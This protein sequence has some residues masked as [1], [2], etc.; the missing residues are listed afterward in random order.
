MLEPVRRNNRKEI[1]NQ[2]IIERYESILKRMGKV[3]LLTY[4]Y[5]IMD[6]IASE[7]G[8]EPTT[9]ARIISG[10]VHEKRRERRA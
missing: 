1:R 7:F 9:V 8:I 2:R 4:S 3:R 10:A 5:E 6:E